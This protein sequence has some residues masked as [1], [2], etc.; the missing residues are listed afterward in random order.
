MP[1]KSHPLLQCF[2]KLMSCSLIGLGLEK[3]SKFDGIDELTA[4]LS[5]AKV[6]VDCCCFKTSSSKM[7]VVHASA[8]CICSFSVKPLFWQ[9]YDIL[10]G[11]ASEC[12]QLAAV[13]S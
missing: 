4:R 12:L 7:L 8:H 5:R 9:N 6:K 10:A 3:E 11:S 1:N 13:T 2:D